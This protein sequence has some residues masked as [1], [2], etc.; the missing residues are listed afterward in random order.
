MGIDR[1]YIYQFL[2]SGKAYFTVLNTLTSKSFSYRLIKA[3]GKELYWL[4][5]LSSPNIYTFAGTII[6]TNDGFK[7]HQGK[8]KYSFNV[9]S[10][11]SVI[12][13]LAKARKGGLPSSVEVLHIGR[14]G[15]CGRPLTDPESIKTGLGPICREKVY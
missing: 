12:W 15:R 10:V 9:P 13:V 11:K 5:V 4:S 14:C 3:R 1:Q 2:T 7:Y 8:G 6:P